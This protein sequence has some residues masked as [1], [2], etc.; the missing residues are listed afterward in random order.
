MSKPLPRTSRRAALGWGL[1]VALV[2][3]GCSPATSPE[4]SDYPSPAPAGASGAGGAVPP[5]VVDP[6]ATLVTQ[7]LQDLSLAHE[8]VRVNRRAHRPLAGRLRRLERLHAQH[9]AE[10]GGLV[11]V[12]TSSVT[13]EKRESKVLQRIA[14]AEQG[15]QQRL[16]RASIVA[17]SG[18]LALL[19]AAMAA[20]VAQ[21]STRL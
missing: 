19:L 7:M 11:T 10:L 21:E 18:A 14:T 6:D 16:M 4:D 12:L 8:R 9:A 20:G 3:S 17:D 1:A 2:G 15:L 13:A 5:A